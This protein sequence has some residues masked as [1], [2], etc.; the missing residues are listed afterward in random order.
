MTYNNHT[1]EIEDIITIAREA[2]K[3]A[4]H[5]YGKEYSIAEKENKTP[6][7]EADLAMHSF[8]IEK[9]SVYHYPILSEEGSHDYKKREGAHCTWIIDPLDGT[10]DFIQ[11][12]G[13][14]SIIIGLIDING[15]ALLGVVYVPATDELYVA[16]KG[17][18]AYIYHFKKELESKEKIH[19]SNKPLNSGRILVSRNH[20]GQW[21]Q[22]IAKKCNMRPLPMGSAGL[23]ICRIAKGDAELYINSSNKSGLWDICAADIILTEAGGLICDTEKNKIQYNVRDVMLQKGYIAIHNA[24]FIKEIGK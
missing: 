7:T 11:K 6:V 24:Q 17:R 19:V 13:E 8:L 23:K 3:I 5:F 9:L 12:T 18:G 4:M 21:E 20:L 10:K 2:G 1:V 15:D 16:E 14:F 22:D